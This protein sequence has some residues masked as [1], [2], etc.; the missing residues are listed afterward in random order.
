MDR[1]CSIEKIDLTDDKNIDQ[2]FIEE[3]N[4]VLKINHLIVQHIFPEVR[5][6]EKRLKEE[7]QKAKMQKRGRRMGKTFKAAD[8]GLIETHSAKHSDADVQVTEQM[9]R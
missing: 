4:K 3:L 1:N 7:I 2:E 6:Q 9:K 5:K 8:N